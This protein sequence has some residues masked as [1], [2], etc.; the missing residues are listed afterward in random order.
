MMRPIVA[1]DSRPTAASCR[2]GFKLAFTIRRKCKAG[3]KIFFRQQRKVEKDFLMSHPGSEVT[4]HVR[5]CNSQPSDT[6]LPAAL[7]RLHRDDLGI[8][9]TASV[10]NRVVPVK[11]RVRRSRAELYREGSLRQKSFFSAVRDFYR[12]RN[13]QA[14][15]GFPAKSLTIIRGRESNEPKHPSKSATWS[16]I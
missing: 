16:S 12:G 1:R 2:Y 11:T 6:R 8:I 5:H 15:F 4:E 13:L 14:W 10:S 7:S 3:Q 9:H